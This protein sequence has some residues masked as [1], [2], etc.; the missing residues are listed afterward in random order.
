MFLCQIEYGGASMHN[1]KLQA[2][3]PTWTFLFIASSLLFTVP[4][5]VL[6]PWSRRGIVAAPCPLLGATP[7]RPAAAAPACPVTPVAVNN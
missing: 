6:A 5:A 7:A 2:N 3:E 1:V 4:P